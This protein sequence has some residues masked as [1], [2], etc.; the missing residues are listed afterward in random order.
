MMQQWSLTLAALGLVAPT[1]ALLRFGCAQLTVQ[2]LD[3]LVNPGQAPASHLHQIIGG[4][5]WPLVYRAVYVSWFGEIRQD[6]RENEK[7]RRKR[8]EPKDKNRRRGGG[9]REKG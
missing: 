6:R 7:K 8:E 9:E 1:S 4:V 3:P 5:S 2:R